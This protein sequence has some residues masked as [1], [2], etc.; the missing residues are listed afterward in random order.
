MSHVTPPV[1]GESHTPGF[2]FVGEIMGDRAVVFIDGNNWYH[3]LKEAGVQN[4]FSLDYKKISEKL[5]GPR[6]WVATRF[7]IGQVD[8]RQGAQ[9]YADSRRFLDGL[10]KTDPRIS[11]HLGR[12][13]RRTEVNEAAKEILRY[14]HGLS[15]QINAQVFSQLVAFVKKHERT[16]F[17]VEKAVDVNLAIDMVTMAISDNYDAAYLLSADGD[18]TKA[19]EFVRSR[20]KKVYAV[21]PG[22]GAQ[23]AAAVNTFI[24]IPGSWVS[25]CY[26]T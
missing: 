13:E 7:Y 6:I 20:G 1:S 25:D 3:H 17:W 12:L 16:Q 10:A 22:Q 11:V 2:L 9:V 14:V 5:L 26:K 21:S 23:L 24:H 15:M 8:V 19:V 18:F 4:T